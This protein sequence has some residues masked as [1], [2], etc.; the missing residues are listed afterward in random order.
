MSEVIYCDSVV[1]RNDLLLQ[2]RFCIFLIQKF[3]GSYSLHIIK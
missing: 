3:A 2:S 1:K